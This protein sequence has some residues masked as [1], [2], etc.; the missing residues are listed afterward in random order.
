MSTFR[1]TEPVR[2]QT[3]DI[4]QSGGDIAYE[5]LDIAIY[6]QNLEKRIARWQSQKENIVNKLI[7]DERIIARQFAYL[8][9]LTIA[10]P[11]TTRL[12]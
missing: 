12:H 1:E 9:K 2:I 5:P 7:Q 6:K 11:S 3:Q 8:E 4:I 10:V